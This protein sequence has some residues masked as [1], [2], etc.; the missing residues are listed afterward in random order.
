MTGPAEDASWSAI[1]NAIK[2]VATSYARTGGPDIST[3]ITGAG[4]G[5]F[6]SRVIADGEE[7]GC[8]LTGGT[9]TLDHLPWSRSTNG[10]TAAAA[11]VQQSVDGGPMRVRHHT[12]SGWLVGEQTRAARRGTVGGTTAR[13][14]P[15]PS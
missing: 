11:A 5:R 3:Q 7:S 1:A 15:E 8:L 10:V 2:A 14:D 4:L 13:P 6:V 9:S 12:R